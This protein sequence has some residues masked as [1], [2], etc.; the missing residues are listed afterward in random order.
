[1][2]F[3]NPK[4]KHLVAPNA[5]YTVCAKKLSDGY[6]TVGWRSFWFLHNREQCQACARLR[7]QKCR[8][9]G[10]TDADCR[11]CVERTGSPCYWVEPDLCSA[12]VGLEKSNESASG[13]SRV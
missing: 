9:C 3:W 11:Q 10:C 7:P 4:K 2:T 6:A 1:M 12:C 8:V 13:D 5:I